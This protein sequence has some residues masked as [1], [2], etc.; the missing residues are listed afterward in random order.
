MITI[1][2]FFH[3]DMTASI[4][5]GRDLLTS[6]R[7]ENGLRQSCTMA[8][9]LF[10]LYMCA[11]FERWHGVIADDGELGIPLVQFRRERLFNTRLAKHRRI[12]LTECQFADDSA[13]LAVTHAGAERALSSFR[14]V[15]GAFGLS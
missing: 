1:I 10:N 9:V 4:R 2:S 14:D 15:A 3:S 12:R 5:V 11:V 7:V 6:I 13:L 8:P